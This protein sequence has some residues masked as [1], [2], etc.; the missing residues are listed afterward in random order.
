[1]S[2]YFFP[3]ALG[4]LQSVRRAVAASDKISIALI[5]VRGRGGSLTQAF[6]E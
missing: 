3:A 6:C 1:M 5:G 4:T 2:R